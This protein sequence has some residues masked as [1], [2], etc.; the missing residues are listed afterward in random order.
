MRDIVL[1]PAGEAL[2]RSGQ[3][4][5]IKQFAADAAIEIMAWFEDGPCSE[6]V[7][8]RPG[9]QSLLAY[10]EPYDLLLCERVWVLSSS[11]AAL[12]PFFKELDARGVGFE[13]AAST[14]DCTSQQCRRRFKS[15]PVLPRAAPVPGEIGR[16]VR[17]RIAKPA[18]LNFAHLVH[19]N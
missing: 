8:K 15:L 9:I 2:G 11:L 16:L 18:R 14:W 17:C 6:E 13:S 7:L 12:K 3:T 1:G 5:L 4:R 19:P 10:S